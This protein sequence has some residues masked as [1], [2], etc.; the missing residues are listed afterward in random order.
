MPKS[1]TAS[2]PP[3]KSSGPGSAEEEITITILKGPAADGQATAH[4]QNATA[5]GVG[6]TTKDG[7]VEVDAEEEAVPLYI[8]ACLNAAAVK[9]LIKCGVEVA[10]KFKGH[11]NLKTVGPSELQQQLGL[12]RKKLQ[13]ISTIDH[14]LGAAEIALA[15]ADVASLAEKPRA[16][17]AD[18]HLDLGATGLEAIKAVRQALGVYHLAALLVRQRRSV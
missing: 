6:N 4:L 17:L 1:G 12:A 7:I 15:K 9:L 10:S 11:F 14:T 16:I 13:E 18:D 8:P 5:A 3:A 2:P